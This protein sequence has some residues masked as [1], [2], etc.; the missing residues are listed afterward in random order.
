ME[1]SL[2]APS[3]FFLMNLVISHH[4]VLSFPP[5]IAKE[6]RETL[7]LME[8]QMEQQIANSLFPVYLSLQAIYKDKAFLQKRSE[9]ITLSD[10]SYMAAQAQAPLHLSH[11]S[12]CTTLFLKQLLEN[13]TINHINCFL[14]KNCKDCVSYTVLD[15]NDSNQCLLIVLTLHMWAQICTETGLYSCFLKWC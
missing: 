11:H 2:Q 9:I 1:Q 12:K 8:D 10:L 6:V 4:I 13:L 15:T 14:I 3:T 5:Q 7:S